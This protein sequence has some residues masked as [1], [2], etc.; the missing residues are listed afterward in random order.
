MHHCRVAEVARVFGVEGNR[1]RAAQ[2]V[3]DRLVDDGHLD[4]AVLEPHLHLVLHLAPEIDL[5]D[6]DVALRVAVDVLELGDF[7]GLKRSTSASASSTTPCDL[8]IARRLMML[9]STMSTMSASAI[10]AVRE[11]FGNDRAG[12]A[13]RLA[14]A[15]RQVTGRPAHGDA[16]VPAAGRP[17]V[18]HQALHQSTPAWRAVS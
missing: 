12:G 15:E 9:P 16:E 14:D 5:G 17:R 6:A 18:L 13:R 4:A 2:L 3:A 10:D 8:P 7:R 11:L 1:R